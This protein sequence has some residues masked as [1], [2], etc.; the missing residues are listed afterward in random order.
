MITFG[1]AVKKY[2]K[3]NNISMTAMFK[4]AGVEIRSR[5]TV[6]DAC[7]HERILEVDYNKVC[8]TFQLQAHTK[9]RFTNAKISKL[10]RD[11]FD[12]RRNARKLA[13]KSDKEH[14]SPEVAFRHKALPMKVPE[15]YVERG[16]RY[17]Q[18]SLALL[19]D[20]DMHSK[21]LEFVYAA[22]DMGFGV[23]H[24]ARTL[25]MN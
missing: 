2:A 13:K 9:P 16:F 21:A 5:A 18:A 1:Q 4:Q 19:R 11:S 15:R 10:R 3:N 6:S 12:L 22:Q 17:Q 20:K 25:E 7:N 8:K 23:G 24:M 14:G